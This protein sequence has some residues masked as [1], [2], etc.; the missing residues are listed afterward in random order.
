[1]LLILG[2]VILRES[3]QGYAT[4]YE[5]RFSDWLAKNS[6]IQPVNA[7]LALIEINDEGLAN[8]HPWPLPPIDYALFLRAGLIFQPSL[9]AIEPVLTWPV[10]MIDETAS[11]NKKILHEQ[12][13]RCPKLLLGSQ[14]G[15]PSDPDLVPVLQSVPALHH[16]KGN[17][18]KLSEFAI[19]EQQPLEELRLAVPVGFTNLPLTE[20]PVRGVPLVFRY[21]GQVVPSFVLQSAMLWLQLTPEEVQVELG[22]FV[23]MGDT[24]RIPIDDSGVMKVNPN[25]Q[26]TRMGL[27]DLLLLVSQIE[28]KHQPLVAPESLTGK[29]LLLART[30][31][32]A[33]TLL[34]PSGRNGSPGE[35]FASA[36]ATIQ[37][38]KFS[39]RAPLMVDLLIIL[40]DL[41]LALCFYRL[42]AAGAIF[43]ALMVLPIY[44][45]C[46]ITLFSSTL[47][48]VP[49]VL[50][51]GL[52]A[53]ALM[54]R[55]T[56]PP[57]Q[58]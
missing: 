7:P 38:Q 54:F 42:R 1:M 10:E 4:A 21:C 56:S 11:E 2:L 53:F 35:L 20:S 28:A 9:L 43:T 17:P 55:L 31:S 52:L 29:V 32:E 46:A 18:S 39:R 14:L 45:M 12:I 48:W 5:N 51:F 13:L 8:T 6:E 23:K 19:V 47:I 34:F 37:N 57:P 22:A 16:V 15:F 36:L 24:F 44:L 33:R 50:P 27:E 26:F 25:S 41:A 49:V 58:K 3:R 40:G 30:D